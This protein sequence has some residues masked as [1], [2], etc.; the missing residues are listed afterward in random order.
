M[1]IKF[2][3]ISLHLNGIKSSENMGR[4]LNILSIKALV[5]LTSKAKEKCHKL[6]MIK[7]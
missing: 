4:Y 2:K 5:C 7:G 1:R 6:I 3:I